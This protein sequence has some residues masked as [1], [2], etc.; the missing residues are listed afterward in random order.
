MKTW[1]II[2]LI[3]MG[4]IV[5]F[6]GFVIYNGYQ[7]VKFYSEAESLGSVL[8]GIGEIG[9]SPYTGNLLRN[10]NT[11]LSICKLSYGGQSVMGESWEIRG[12]KNNNCIVFY[13]KP[14]MKNNDCYNYGD[15]DGGME[16]SY[17]NYI[18]KLP[19]EFYSKAERIE[20]EKLFNSEYCKNE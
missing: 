16:I 15:C 1:K 7:Y 20:W 12:L 10:F 13:S 3:V 9:K 18:C 17:K 5:L 19:Y 8:F 14:D 4:F 2:L 6:I 11:Y